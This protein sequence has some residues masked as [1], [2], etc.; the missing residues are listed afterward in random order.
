[1]QQRQATANRIPG[2]SCNESAYSMWSTRLGLSLSP[3]DEECIN[4]GRVTKTAALTYEALDVMSLG[5]KGQNLFCRHHTHPVRF[6]HNFQW[7][8]V[9][10]RSIQVDAKRKDT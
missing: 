6:R 10:R 8:V 9:A 5:R 3:L 2:A 7:S 1:M 4:N